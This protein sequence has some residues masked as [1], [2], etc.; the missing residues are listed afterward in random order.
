MSYSVGHSHDSD[1]TLLLLWCRPAAVARI[2]S[3]AWELPGASG[4][5][6]KIKKKK[7]KKKKKRQELE[8]VS[9]K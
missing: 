2:G 7:K 6:I 8:S 1:P 5:A 4:V 3:I 9:V